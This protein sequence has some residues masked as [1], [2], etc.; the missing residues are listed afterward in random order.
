MGTSNTSTAAKA[1]ELATA[2]TK[3]CADAGIT[4]PAEVPALIAFANAAEDFTTALIAHQAAQ[5]AY[6]NFIATHGADDP[7]QD[8]YVQQANSAREIYELAHRRHAL[9]LHTWRSSRGL[10]AA[11]PIAA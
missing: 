11:L 7:G 1:L 6:A 2:I 4:D 9:A 3:A 8:Y 5:R 10:S